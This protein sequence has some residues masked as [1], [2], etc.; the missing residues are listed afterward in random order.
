MLPA[1][2]FFDLDDTIVAF[3]SV[4]LPVW[5]EVCETYEQQTGELQARELFK[6]IRRSAN[7]FWGD[8]ERHRIGRLDIE[9][10]RR[11]V[12]R[13]AFKDLGSDNV[14]AAYAI[15]DEYSVKRVERITLFSGAKGTLEELRQR[16]VNLALITNGE[17]EGQNAK[18]DRFQLRPY[19]DRTFVEGDVGFGKPDPRV[20]RLALETM[21]VSPKDVWM[22]GDNL[23]WDV[24]APQELGIYGIWNDWRAKGLPKSS[25]VIPDRIIN[26]ISE[27]VE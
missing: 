13:Q 10:A 16:G 24:G 26:S 3:D 12:V 8:K 6:A 15:A 18:I 27:L 17:S 22:V 23:E 21:Q 25:G 4:S 14:N 2:I 19:F 20:Y 1:A 7:W 5:R 9:N 11:Q